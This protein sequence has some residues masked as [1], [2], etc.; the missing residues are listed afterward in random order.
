MR[1]V[2]TYKYINSIYTHTQTHTHTP[3]HMPYICIVFT[4][5]NKLNAKKTTKKHVSKHSEMNLNASKAIRKKKTTKN[6]LFEMREH[7][8]IY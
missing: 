8:N 1:Y 7:T 5:A 3:V 4:T 6:S 2:H